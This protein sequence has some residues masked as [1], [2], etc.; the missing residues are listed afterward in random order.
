MIS[1]SLVYLFSLALLSTIFYLLDSRTTWRVFKVIPAVVFI[2][3][4]SML[5][6]VPFAHLFN[7]FTK[8]DENMAYLGEIG[9]AC[10]MGAPKY[11]LLILLA[12]VASIASQMI[13]M[14]IEILNKTTTIVLVASALGVL[15]SFTKLKSL[16]GS[17]EVATTMLYVIMANF[18]LQEHFLFKVKSMKS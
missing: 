10:S 15:G 16:N 8:S 12:L 9:C 5:F 14:N 6:L 13:A 3:A 17:S 1:S 11:W 18:L 4:F 7:R 2:Y